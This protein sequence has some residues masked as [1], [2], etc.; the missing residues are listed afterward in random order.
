VSARPPTP[1]FDDPAAPSRAAPLLELRGVTAG[2]GRIQVLH[3]VDL[4]VPAVR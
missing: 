2:Y 1:T 4:V 3:G